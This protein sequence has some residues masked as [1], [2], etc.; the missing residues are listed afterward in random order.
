MWRSKRN[1]N[2]FNFN[3]DNVTNM[4]YMFANCYSLNKL[5]LSKFNTEKVINM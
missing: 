1:I 3:T 4:E 5:D 2:F